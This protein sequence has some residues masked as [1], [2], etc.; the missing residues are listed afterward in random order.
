MHFSYVDDLQDLYYYPIAIVV[1][2]AVGAIG[3]K[4]WAVFMVRM[5]SYDN[6][7]IHCKKYL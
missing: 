5:M 6:I 2:V 3:Y 1:A 7:C 4:I